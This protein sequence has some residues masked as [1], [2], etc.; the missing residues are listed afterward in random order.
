[1]PDSPGPKSQAA[2]RRYRG[3]PFVGKTVEFVPFDLDIASEFF[4]SAYVV[5]F[6]S[7][8]ACLI[9][10]RSNGRWVLPGGTKERGKPGRKPPEEKSLR[11]LGRSLATSSRSA[12]IREHLLILNPG[13][14]IYPTLSTY[15]SS[16][17]R[18]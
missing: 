10:R 9:T 13:C 17:G 12:R 11:K 6:V 7:D 4:G 18:T 15:A 16:A 3:L 1:M 8:D 14:H 5:P 2:T